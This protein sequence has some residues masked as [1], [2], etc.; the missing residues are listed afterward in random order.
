MA[1]MTLTQP[2]VAPAREAVPKR[3]AQDLL[4]ASYLAAVAQGDAKALARLY[5]ESSG[6]VYAIALRVLAEPSEAEEVALDVYTQVWRSAERFDPCR[7][8]A[9]TWLTTLARSRAIDRLR[10]IASR[11]EREKPM[12]ESWDW[13]SSEAS[14]EA[15]SIRS[16]R[17][18]R[19]RSALA[20]L[21]ERERQAIELAFFSGLSH[22]ELARRLGEP[23]GTVKSRVRNGMLKLRRLM[24]E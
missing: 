14:P 24:A 19:V 16:E 18:R 2:L 20:A 12:E 23:L 7:G 5:D 13:K 10:A 22:S 11:R 21:P 17:R 1:T 15:A 9:P 6:L 8:S 4:W 3:A